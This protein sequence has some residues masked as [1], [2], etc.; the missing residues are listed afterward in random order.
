MNIIHVEGR[1]RR[2]RRALLLLRARLAAA[3]RELSTLLTHIQRRELSTLYIHIQERGVHI[4]LPLTSKSVETTFYITSTSVEGVE[5]AL[6]IHMQ[7]RGVC[8]LHPHPRAW[9]ASCPHYTSTCKSVEGEGGAPGAP[10]RPSPRGVASRVGPQSNPWHGAGARAAG[11]ADGERQPAREPA[12]QRGASHPNNRHRS[13]APFTPPTVRTPR[14]SRQPCGSRPSPKAR[15]QTWSRRFR[16]A[17][18]R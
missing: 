18:R 9:R 3:G 10:S 8:I 5:T 4:V 1:G 11:D 12:T 15:A 7:E 2:A 17:H 6:Y 14:S 16:L 13:A